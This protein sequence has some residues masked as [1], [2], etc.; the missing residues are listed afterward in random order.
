MREDQVE[1]RCHRDFRALDALRHPAFLGGTVKHRKI[2]LLLGGVQ[3][4]EQVEHL[5]GDD[6]R[7]GIVAVHLVDG[8]D[9]PQ[10]D[11]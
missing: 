6:F 2:Q 4:R 11:F 5:A 7:T 9:R 10:P 8:D 3:R 1:Q